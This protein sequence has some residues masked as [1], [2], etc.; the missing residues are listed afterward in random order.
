MT[1]QFL[2]RAI[3]PAIAFACLGSSMFGQAVSVAEVSGV[4]SDATGGSVPGAEVK[5]TEIEKQFSRSATS[6]AAGRFTFPGLPVGPYRLDVSASGFKGYTQTGLILQ[7][8]NS[9]TLNVTM[10]VG[11]VSE[12]VEVSAQTSMVETR[13]N[14]ISQVID[15]QRISELPLNGRQPTQLI[16]LSGAALATPGGEIGRAHV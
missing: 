3:L 7:V 4:V 2:R 5:I 8:G 10:Q 11:N 15:S 6:D 13:D 9:V 12:H 1:I 16:L 14:T